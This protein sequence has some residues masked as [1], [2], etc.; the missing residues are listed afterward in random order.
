MNKVRVLLLSGCSR[1][2]ELT[3]KLT[4]ANIAYQALDADVNDSVASAAEK[5]T[6]TSRYPMVIVESSTGT[7]VIFIAEGASQLGTQSINRTTHIIGCI[8][9]DT[10][11][12]NIR[13]LN[14]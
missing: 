3:T 6:G 10:I 13:L 11:L 2:H 1:C 12:H 5:V 9:V 8:N 4:E 14:K 7:T